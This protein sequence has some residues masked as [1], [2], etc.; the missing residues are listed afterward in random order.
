MC[1]GHL[2]VQDT[3]GGMCAGRVAT[4]ATCVGVWPVHGCCAAVWHVE[5][6]VFLV[7]NI[8]VPEAVVFGLHPARVVCHP[9]H[10][11]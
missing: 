11:V 8:R 6:Y 7:G 3:G 10:N 4:V 5:T 1:P 9:A 2:R